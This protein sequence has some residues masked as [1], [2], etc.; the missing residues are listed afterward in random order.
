MKAYRVEFNPKTRKSCAWGFRVTAESAMEAER[1]ARRH[2][3][4]SGE[5]LAHFKKPRVL[6]EAGDHA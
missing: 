1:I 3:A 4:L 5:T 2:L 6:L